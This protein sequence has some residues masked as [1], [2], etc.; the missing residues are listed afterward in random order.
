MTAGQFAR[1]VLS[2]GALKD[3]FRAGSETSAFPLAEGDGDRYG[4]WNEFDPSDAGELRSL[5]ETTFMGGARRMAMEYSDLPGSGEDT[6]GVFRADY[7]ETKTKLKACELTLYGFLEALGV[8]GPAKTYDAAAN[9]TYT[10]S[11]TTHATDTVEVRDLRAE[12]NEWVAK[13][14]RGEALDKCAVHLLAGNWDQTTDNIRVG[15]DGSFHLFDYDRVEEPLHNRNMAVERANYAEE[16][17]AKI[18]IGRE[19][20]TPIG[21]ESGPDTF[22][23]S[24]EEI[25]DRAVEIATEIEEQGQKERLVAAATAYQELAINTTDEDVDLRRPPAELIRNN[26]EN[27]SEASP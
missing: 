25:A 5:N 14:D 17:L 18:D 7:D 11:V 16:S 20:H 19:K 12:H 21:S 22:D 8:D 9:A 1:S 6:A 15:E 3:G 2:D 24:K 23:I 4:G 13:I 26:I 27:L 10:A